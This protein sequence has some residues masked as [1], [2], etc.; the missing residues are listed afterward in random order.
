[1]ELSIIIVNFNVRRLLEGALA[2]ICKA[3]QGLMSEILVVDNASQDGSVAMVREKFPTV[4][5]LVNTQNLG[6]GRANNQALHLATGKYIVFINPDTLVQEDT[7]TTLIQFLEHRADVGMAGCKILNPDGTLQL[8]CRRSF[9]TPWV[10]FTKMVGLSALFPRSRIFGRYN[11]TY[12]DPDQAAE[13][14]AISGSFMLVRRRA[15][16]QVGFFDETWFMYGEDLDLCYRFRQA[17][18]KIFYLPATKIVHF[19]GESSKQSDFDTIRLF[20]QAMQLFVAKYHKSR[21][22]QLLLHVGILLRASL[23]LLQRLL[24]L[25]VLP[26]IDLGFLNLALILA[27]WLRFGHLRHLAAYG[28]VTLLYSFVWIV[29]LSCLAA[30]TRH[31][32]AAGYVTLAVLTGLVINTSLTFFFNQIAYSRAVVLIAGGFNVVFLAGWRLLWRGITHWGF[33]PTDAAGERRL[34]GRRTLIIG[35]VPSATLLLDKLMRQIDGGYQI[36]GLVSFQPNEIGQEYQGVA[37]LGTVD[38]LPAIIR[39]QRIQDVIFSTARIAYDQILAVMHQAR[40]LGINYR[41]VPENF[42]VIIGKSRI[43]ELGE[44]PFIEIDNQYFRPFSMFTKRLFDVVIAGGVLLVTAPLFFYWHY[45]KRTPRAAR[46]I[47]GE[48]DKIFTIQEFTQDGGRIG[49]YLPYF[50]SVFKGDLSLVGA[51]IVPVSEPQPPGK[52]QLLLKPGLTGLVQIARHQVQN[53]TDKQRYHLYYLKNYTL[54]LDLE[55]LIKAFGKM[56]KEKR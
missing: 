46:Q 2:S 51:E 34:W 43:D 54:M 53:E 26:L 38:N 17:G 32:L 50:V 11:L 29:T 19:K 1:M 39:R 28:I 52:D 55:I 4:Q 5:L 16:E 47:Q 56:R 45:L 49:K 23:H 48:N 15:L 3:T 40:G 35:D 6:F 12:L 25:L 24:T 9:P 37:V 44:F 41:I 27:L 42:E 22:L 30:Y 33:Y 7:F 14:E 10:A 8:A 21:V 20:Y 36:V 18:W 13:V 31:R